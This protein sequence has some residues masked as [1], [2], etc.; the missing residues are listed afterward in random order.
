MVTVQPCDASSGVSYGARNGPAGSATGA[1][2]PPSR[3]I[4]VRLEP[5]RWLTYAALPEGWI[6]TA[7]GSRATSNDAFTAPFAPSPT[8]TLWGH[9]DVTTAVLPSAV[10]ATPNAS[11]G[12]TTRAFSTILSPSRASTSNRPGSRI[13]TSSLSPVATTCPGR[14]GSESDGDE[15]RSPATG[16]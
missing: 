7:R 11:A 12:T 5:T 9:A 2:S 15:G 8:L 13:V 16:S 6:A 14:P 4:F 3:G 1:A 10:T